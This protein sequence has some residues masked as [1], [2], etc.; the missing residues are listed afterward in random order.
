MTSGEGETVSRIST[1]TPS[2][3]SSRAAPKRCLVD[4]NEGFGAAGKHRQIE[5]HQR[6]HDDAEG[7]FFA[8]LK[9]ILTV[10]PKR[11]SS[12]NSLSLSSKIGW[13]AMNFSYTVPP[14]QANLLFLIANARRAIP[15]GRT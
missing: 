4:V 6:I 11:S 10:G 7:C 2:G 13:R 15:E 9:D 8:R 5:E 14:D 1:T 3:G 12:A